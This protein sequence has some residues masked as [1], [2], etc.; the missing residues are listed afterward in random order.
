MF[1]SSVVESNDLQERLY[2]RSKFSYTISKR[3]DLIITLYPTAV[4]SRHQLVRLHP[5]KLR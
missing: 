1:A 5:T 4:K 2:Y 3:F